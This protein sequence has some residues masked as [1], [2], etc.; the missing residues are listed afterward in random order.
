MVGLFYDFGKYDLVFDCVLFGVN[1]QVDYLM[2]GVVL[3]CVWVFVGLCFVVE[4]IVYVI[5]GYYVGLF[6][7]YGV[8]SSMECWLDVFCN[9]IVFE[10]WDV[11]VF[12]WCF[13]VKE[14][15][16][17]V[18]LVFF[19]FDLFVV[20][21][22][23]FFCLVDVD[24][25]DIEVF[26]VWLNGIMLDWDWLYLVEL[27]LYWMWVFDVYMVGFFGDGL[28]NCLCVEILLYVWQGVVMVSGFF[29]LI[30]FIGGG[31][32]LVLMGFVLDYVECYG[33]CWIIYMVF[34]IFIIDQIVVIFCGF[35]G[36]VVLEYY[37]VIDD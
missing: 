21:C 3:F 33:Y 16:V 4:I 14:L 24:F 34:Y 7:R 27:L 35:F 17:L 30:V 26:Y 11:V 8:D 1:E 25:C 18:G 19:L 6:D 15:V 10:I 31:K 29:I 5:L 9:L 12:D 13:V 22:M 37:L 36:D 23:V 2:V 20:V 32:I 28:I